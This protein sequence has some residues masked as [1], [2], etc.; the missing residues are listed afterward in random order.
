MGCS[1]S[2]TKAISSNVMELELGAK[3]IQSLSYPNQ[4]SD[5]IVEDC[6]V[7]WLLNDST[8]D[9][10]LKKSKLQHIISTVKI[11]T[12]HEACITYIMNI[13]IERIFLVISTTETFRESI[14][15][16]PQIEKFYILNSSTREL[17]ESTDIIATSNMFYD[18]DCL[19]QQLKMDVEMCRLDHLAVTASVSTSQDD[20]T[21]A[22]MKRQE[23]SFLYSQLMREI[24][25]RLKFENNAKSEFINFCRLSY[26]N[27]NEQLRIIDDFEKNYRPQKALWWL[28]R[29]SFVWRILQRSQRAFEIDTLYK[30]GFIVKH[31]HTQLN[32]FQESNSLV[33]EN[34]SI[35]YRG[36]TMRNNKF[37]SLVKNNCGGLLSFG[38]LFIAHIDKEISI[39]FLRSRL[40]TYHQS[41]GIIF[42]IHID[43]KVYSRRSPFAAIDKIH[44]DEQ[45]EKNGILFSLNTV[46]RIDFVEKFS[47]ESR[48]IIWTV[49]LS[50]IDDDD[51]QLL[52]HVAS[53]RTDE[54]HYNPLSYIGKL[55]MDMGEYTYAQQFFI[56]MLKD[57]SVRSQPRRLVR[58]HCGLGA[59]YMITGD[60][61]KAL[62][63]YEQALDVSLSYLP[64]MHIHLASIYEAIGKCYFHQSN[65]IKTVENYEKAAH[66]I[67]LNAQTNNEQFTN[68]LQ[69][70]INSINKLLNEK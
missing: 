49:K 68:D 56:G 10:E 12:D 18:I 26:A 20:N 41:I 62:E 7:V 65:Y 61:I 15:N 67:E 54:I 28:T 16:S 22:D 48:N 70:R 40:A 23:A 8:I 13:R 9:I 29:Q 31:A 44:V 5:R 57:A 2:K 32:V 52:H 46:F 51:Q 35:V 6:I 33:P 43:G 45:I 19:C 37:N 50:L 69:T 30:L 42:E 3:S 64:P 63:Q 25:Y 11:F 38:N 24:L 1:Q 59:N 58:V 60:Y 47:E 17:I 39:N 66:I 4:Q 53:L 55:Y 36:K 27:D 14:Q 21:S 34:L